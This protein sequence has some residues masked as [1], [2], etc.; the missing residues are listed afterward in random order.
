MILHLTQL[1][2]FDCIHEHIFYLDKIRK[3]Y[4]LVVAKIFPM[5]DFFYCK[6]DWNFVIDTIVLQLDKK[7]VELS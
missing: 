7:A 1:C 2:T 5:M 3:Q 6:E 4:I